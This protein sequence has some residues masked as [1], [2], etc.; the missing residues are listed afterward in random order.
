MYFKMFILKLNFCSLCVYLCVCVLCVYAVLCV[1]LCE[2]G[3]QRTFGSWSS[4]TLGLCGIN[5]GDQTVQQELL[6]AVPS[7]KS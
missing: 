3:G 5:S 6:P 1:S 4:P 2:C 7:Y